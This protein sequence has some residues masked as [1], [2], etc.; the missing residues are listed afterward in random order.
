MRTVRVFSYIVRLDAFLGTDKYRAL[1]HHPGLAE[2]N[3]WDM[4]WPIVARDN[5]VPVG[6][7]HLRMSPCLKAGAFRRSWCISDAR[8]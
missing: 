1:A 2:W 7:G 4:N 5:T 8:E 6:T 3:L